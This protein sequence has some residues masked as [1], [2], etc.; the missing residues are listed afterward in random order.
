MPQL[1]AK[2]INILSILDPITGVPMANTVSSS[3]N[4]SIPHNLN[5]IL[6]NQLFPNAPSVTTIKPHDKSSMSKSLD[7]KRDLSLVSNSKLSEK[8]F[9]FLK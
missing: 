2:I 9:Y 6:F 5:S 3:Y 4:L 8:Y 1:G 7:R